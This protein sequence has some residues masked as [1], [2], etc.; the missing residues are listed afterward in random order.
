MNVKSQSGIGIAMTEHRRR[1]EIGVFLPNAKNG[2]ALSSNAVAYTPSYEEN[3]AI[4]LL[5]EEVGIDYV[6]SM[7]KWRG[8]G[9]ATQF[10]DA[11]LDSFTLTTAL[12]AV[13]KRVRLI[14]TVNPL[15]S[16]PAVMAKMSPPSIA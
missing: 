5:A 6:F 1:L 16:N 8:F 10:W 4:T 13:T 14:A 2:F 9:G 3:L 15:L 12:A 11:A 7:L